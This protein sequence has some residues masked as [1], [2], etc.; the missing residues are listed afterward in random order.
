M[1]D[2]I[3][4]HFPGSPYSEKLRLVM[5]Y[6][7][8]GWKSVT[9]PPIMP[10][11]DV[12]ALTGGY[13]RTPFLQIGA[14]IYCDTALI[15]EVLE[16]LHPLPALYPE[17]GRDR[18][19]ALTLGQWADNTLFWAAVTYNRGASQELPAAVFEDRKAMGFDV[20]WWQPA[21]AAPAYR[22]YLQRLLELLD[23]R[24][25]LL[26]EQPCS[27]DFCAFHPL[28]LAHLRAPA[29]MDALQAMPAVQR[30]LER[31][32]AIG[33][34]SSQPLDAAQAIAT[35]AGCEPVPVGQGPLDDTRFQNEHG[36][37]LGSQVRVAAQSFGLEPSEGELIAATP[38]H[39][40]LRRVDARAGTLH[41]HFPR[42]GYVL[43]RR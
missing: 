20:D 15:C 14:D 27:A 2:L 8:L 39:Y 7:Q 19:M 42:I 29:R 37:A 30:W 41:V 13:R 24:P 16:K 33:H 26:G 9:V 43:K 4:H 36:I 21:D 1:A 22:V 17:E 3:L 28:W 6:K 31:M 11:P 35:A 18:A 12:V 5:G 34:G 32:Q 10:K 38:M 40:S 23:Q 25:Y